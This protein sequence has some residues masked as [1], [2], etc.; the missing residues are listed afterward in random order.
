MVSGEEGCVVFGAEVVEVGSGMV[1]DGF[2]DYR[3]D[4]GWVAVGEVDFFTAEKGVERIDG[5]A[6][7][8]AAADD[9]GGSVLEG[10]LKARDSRRVL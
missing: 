3:R 4:F 9:E 1:G 6:R 10:L 5:G 2:R 8:A 7:C